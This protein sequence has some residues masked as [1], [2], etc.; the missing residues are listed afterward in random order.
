MTYWQEFDCTFSLKFSRLDVRRFSSPILVFKELLK[1]VLGSL[2]RA[3][4]V[5]DLVRESSRNLLEE[6][7]DPS[8]LLARPTGKNSTVLFRRINWPPKQVSSHYIVFLECG[9]K[10]THHMCI[11]AFI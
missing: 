9:V 7:E 11:C 6:F 5:R 10:L 2:Y 4:R 8:D 3:S 1:T